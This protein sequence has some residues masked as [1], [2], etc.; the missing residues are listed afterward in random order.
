MD[1]ACSLSPSSGNESVAYINGNGR[2]VEIIEIGLNEASLECNAFKERSGE[3]G[4]GLEAP[5]LDELRE[6][7]QKALKDLEIARLNSTMFEEK[8]QRISEAAI[9]LKDEAT[10]AWDDANDALSN[11]PEI[12]NEEAIAKE[13]VQKATMALSLAEARL[14]VPV[15]SMKIEKENN[16]FPKASKKAILSMKVEGK[17][18]QIARAELRRVQ[19]RK[20]E[21]QKEVDRLNQVAEQAQINAS[22]AEEDMGN[23]MLLAEQA[24]VYE[25]EAA[26]RV[27]DAEISLQ[28]AEKN[29]ALSSIS[30]V[31]SAVEGTVAGEVSHRS[32]ADG[33]VERDWDV[34]AEVAEVLE[35]LPDGQLEEQTLL[36]KSSGSFLLLFSLSLQTWMSSQQLQFFVVLWSLLE[37]NCLSWCLGHYLLEQDIITTSIDEVS[38][39]A[40]PLV[41]EEEASLLTCC[42]CY[43]QVLYLCPFSRQFLE[44]K[45]PM[46]EIAATVNE[47][48]SRHLSELTELS[49]TSGSSLGYDFSQM[50]S[51]NLNLSP[52]TLQMTTNSLKDR[53]QYDFS[54][55]CK[56]GERRG[57]FILPRREEND[58]KIV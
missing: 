53:W 18:Q 49:E 5:G 19:N 58:M 36:K 26:Q 1:V 20:E 45:L 54:S 35:P 50:M 32:S 6:L 22:K 39:T 14:Q 25:L 13:G 23:I 29:L 30:S 16:G 47:F 41:N 4:G 31:D 42:G 40:K 24:V 37:S 48:R 38:T 46:S 2:D 21:L 33:V 57:I 28:R 51:K 52:P 55:V 8:A 9:A 12:V 7:L 27:D 44:A 43:L 3:E 56:Q 15:D 34:P 11:L 17:N 10:N